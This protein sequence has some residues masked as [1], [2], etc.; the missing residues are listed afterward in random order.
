MFQTKIV[1]KIKIHILCS[2]TIFENR[3]VYDIIWKNTVEPDRPQMTMRRMH[4]ECWITTATN[5]HSEYVI[6][7][8][9]PQ[10]SG[11][12]NAPQSGY[13]KAPQC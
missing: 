7:I 5:T 2:I 1:E 11:Y 10:Q 12:A 6:L 8:A 9:F 4:F 13:A 3:V